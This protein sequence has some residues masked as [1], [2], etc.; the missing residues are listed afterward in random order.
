MVFDG[1]VSRALILIEDAFKKD[2][3]PLFFRHRYYNNKPCTYLDTERYSVMNF[4]Q[5]RKQA[6]HIDVFPLQ[7]HPRTL[8]ILPIPLFKPD[9]PLPTLRPKHLIPAAQLARIGP[10]APKH[11]FLLL[12]VPR[13]DDL[14]GHAQ[15]QRHRVLGQVPLRM[16]RH[17]RQQRLVHVAVKEHGRAAGAPFVMRHLDAEDVGVQDGRMPAERLRHFGRG[18]VFRAPPE[19]V[20]DAVDEEEAA[21]RIP[22][23]EVARAEPRVALLED[24]AQDLAV[25]GFFVVEVALEVLLDVR[26]VELVQE[27]A[28]LAARHLAA[29]ALVLRIPRWH[30]G[31]EVNFDDGGGGA[32]E[33]ADDA[34]C[35]SDGACGER[36]GAHVPGRRGG[37]RR[38][39]EFGNRVDGEAF[40]EAF[41]YVWAKA[42]AKRDSHRVLLV[43]IFSR[44]G[45]DLRRRGKQVAAGFADV[46]DH[47]AF[48]GTHLGPKGLVGEF[49]AEDEGGANAQAWAVRE[50]SGG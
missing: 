20:A 30:F 47:R 29:E 18:D 45:V 1:C 2:G 36:V 26:G 7:L 16:L 37:F 10:L 41:P 19:G 13:R 8:Q 50:N 4:V 15:E 44:V 31:F 11:V 40:L 5:I 22:A 42:V 34:P 25:G 38:G 9:V 48:G 3:R 12:V 33:E 35:T 23:D 14:L 24:V 27:L 6:D 28:G 43:Q 21:L 46:L 17:R 32:E 49:A 39:V